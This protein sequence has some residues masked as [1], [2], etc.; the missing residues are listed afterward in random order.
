[1]SN[2]YYKCF[3]VLKHTLKSYGQFSERMAS[4]KDLINTNDVGRIAQAAPDL[5]IISFISCITVIMK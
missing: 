3:K 4:L 1:M 2:F 5:L